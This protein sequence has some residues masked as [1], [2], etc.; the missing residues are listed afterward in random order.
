MLSVR[1]ML[2][3]KG[4]A[5][6]SITPDTSVFD[7]LKVMNEK[8]I[9]AVLVMEDEELVGIFSERDYARKV[10]LAGRSSKITEVKELMTCKV[11]CIDPSR[12][13]QDVME[14]MNEHRFRHVPVMESK[15][16]IGVLSSGDVMRGVVAE[17]KNTIESLES[18]LLRQ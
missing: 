7:A 5:V 8:N 9:G 6:V 10:I 14:L 4:S 18:Y 11:Y 12:T 3:E 16:V 17:Q 15:K 13:I 2:S 1:Q